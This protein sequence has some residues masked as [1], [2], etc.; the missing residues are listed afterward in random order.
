MSKITTSL[1]DAAVTE[2]LFSRLERIRKGRDLTQQE[3]AEFFL[4]TT[5]KTYRS[6]RTGRCSLNLFLLAL[7]Q[8][9]LLEN[10]ELLIPEQTVRPRAVLKELISLS[11]RK[12]SGS[13]G[14]VSRISHAQGNQRAHVLSD[15]TNNSVMEKLSKRHKHITRYKDE[16]ES[17]NGS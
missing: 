13:A 10:L 15:A 1:S 17:D 12:G 4:S 16:E 3:F 6:I 5:V 7:R 11:S 9:G 14:Q 8:L 2:E